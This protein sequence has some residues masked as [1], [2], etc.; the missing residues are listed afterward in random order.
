M[1]NGMVDVLPGVMAVATAPNY[2]RF[3]IGPLERGLGTPLGNALRR[4]LLSSLPGSAITSIR[5]QGVYHEFSCIPNVREDVTEIVLNVKNIRLRSYSDRPVRMHLSKYGPGEVRAGD[6]EVPANVELVNPELV[7]AT[8]DGPDAHLEMELTVERGRGYIS[9]EAREGLPIGTIPVDAIFSPIPRVNYV[10]EPADY[11]LLSAAQDGTEATRGRELQPSQV[12]GREQVV[13]E[14]WTDGTIEPGEALSMA[15]QYLAQHSSL[16][17]NFNR[18]VTA[19][20][21]PELPGVEIP[22]HLSEMSVEDLGLS[23]RT[24]NCLKRSGI[25]RLGQILRMDK[26]ELLSLRNFGEKS[27]DE[28]YNVLTSRNLIPPGTPLEASMRDEHGRA[29]V[30]ASKYADTEAESE[31]QAQAQGTAQ[32]AE[33]GYPEWDEREPEPDAFTAE[34]VEGQEGPEVAEVV[35]HAGVSE[36]TLEMAAGIYIEGEPA[37]EE[38]SFEGSTEVQSPE[39]EIDELEIEPADIGGQIEAETPTSSTTKSKRSRAK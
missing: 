23:M 28:L 13:I 27:F 15:G 22:P 21:S 32:E 7:L 1:N 36:G 20:A 39:V 16:I 38:M 9:F 30:E 11:A 33:V 17:A 25:T 35:H 31:A 19:G 18:T 4:I 34:P 29:D 2:G 26:K 3:V 24:F 8:L 37:S 10:V 6:I 5:I 12:E 14:I